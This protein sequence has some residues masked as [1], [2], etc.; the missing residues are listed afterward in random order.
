MAAAQPVRSV[1]NTLL[2][3][4]VLALSRAGRSAALQ[5]G[6]RRRD[7]LGQQRADC[8][9]DGAC[10]V[11]ISCACTRS[12]GAI[13]PIDEL[14]RS[15]AVVAAADRV[16][17]PG[18]AR[19]VR[20][21]GLFVLLLLA[22]FPLLAGVLLVGGVA[23]LPYVDTNDWGGLML[24]VII[25]FVT[26]AGALPLGILLALGRRSQLPVDQVSCPSDSSSC[27]VACRCSR[28]CSCRP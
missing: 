17:R 23:G 10:W 22:V 13:I 26:V 8:T 3:L 21:R 4:L 24:D 7:D 16:R 1:S 25:S 9:G 28:F 18:D 14:W 19:R 12:S 15:V 11:F 2:T 6:D 27:G 20:H 5:L